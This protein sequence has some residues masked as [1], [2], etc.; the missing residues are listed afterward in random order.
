MAIRLKKY[1]RNDAVY[2]AKRGS[3]GD[4]A[5]PYHQPAQIKVRWDERSV[6]VVDPD[7]RVVTFNAQILANTEIIE[8]SLLFRGTMADVKK[9]VQFPTVPSVK[10]GGREVRKVNRTGDFKGRPFLRE[11]Y[12]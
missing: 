7:M 8:G 5:P 9:I 1:L 4:G 10:Q 3:K 12:L 6:Q 2:W 11:V